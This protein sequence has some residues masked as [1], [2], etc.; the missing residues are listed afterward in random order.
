MESCFIVHF[1]KNY[2]ILSCMETCFLVS[3]QK[4]ISDNESSVYLARIFKVHFFW[5]DY[6]GQIESD[7]IIMFLWTFSS[8]NVHDEFRLSEVNKKWLQTHFL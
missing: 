3:N 4:L 1:E 7:L 6:S 8:S 5:Y 2:L